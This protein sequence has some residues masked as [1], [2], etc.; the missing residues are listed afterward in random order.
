MT[1]DDLIPPHVVAAVAKHGLHKVAGVMH[2]I[3][4]LTLKE[5]AAI[6]GAKAYLRR[7]EARAIADG[8][9]AYAVVTGEKIAENPAMMALLQKSLMPALM[10]AGIGAVPHLLSRD[11]QEHQMSAMLPSMGIGAL[12]AGG[13]NAMSELNSA[14]RGPLGPALAERINR[15]PQ[16]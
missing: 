15:P 5:A 4:E 7:K 8:I 9:G 1:L 16:P 12:L 14:T 2:G 6:I 10:G 3:P 11:P 13:G